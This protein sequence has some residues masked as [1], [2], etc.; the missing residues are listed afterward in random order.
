LSHWIVHAWAELL[1]D[2]SQFAP[3]ALADRQAPY[4]ESP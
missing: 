1:F 3:H 4:R 2:F